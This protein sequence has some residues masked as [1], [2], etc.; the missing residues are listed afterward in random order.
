VVYAPEMNPSAYFSKSYTTLSV[1]YKLLSK[2]SLNTGYKYGLK[3][4]LGYTFKFDGADYA[5]AHDSLGLSGKQLARECIQHRPFAALTGSVEMGDWKLS[6]RETYRVNFRTDS[7]S[8]QDKWNSDVVVYEKNPA[9]M[10]LKSRIKVDYS[11]PGK[12]VK[13][14][15]FGEAATTLNEKDCPWTD[16]EGKPLYGGQYLRSGKAS[17]GVRWKIDKHNALSLSYLYYYK[18]NRDI[19]I[20]GKNS[21]KRQNVELTTE[22]IHTHA[23]VLA[24][25]L[26]Y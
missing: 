21:T 2:Q 24:Y 6:L 8:V 18:Q 15:A 3:L 17:F 16:A 22:H 10:E 11:I 12:P 26:G 19:N 20:T 7:V 1:G 9:L 13:L 4:D 23:I 25:D 14:F 5:K